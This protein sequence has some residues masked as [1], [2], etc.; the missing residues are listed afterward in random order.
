MYSLAEQSMKVGS[1]LL[2]TQM[3][4]KSEWNNPKREKMSNLVTEI[5]RDQS[6]CSPNVLV[7]WCPCELGPTRFA[8]KNE[9]RVKSSTVFSEMGMVIKSK[10]NRT[11]RESKTLPEQAF[12]LF[13]N[14]LCLRRCSDELEVNRT[15][16]QRAA[17]LKFSASFFKTP[18]ANQIKMKQRWTEN[19]NSYLPMPSSRD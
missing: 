19:E 13:R 10:R 15:T 5:S 6:L 1:L 9:R 17:G 16:E 14:V 2:E 11:K 4:M 7:C 8:R 18:N 3:S 12:F